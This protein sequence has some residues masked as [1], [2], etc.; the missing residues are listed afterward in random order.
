MQH[1]D[2]GEPAEGTQSAP[3]FSGYIP[4]GK[5]LSANIAYIHMN[6]YQ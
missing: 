4:V 3:Q 1:T 6:T 5:S 2:S